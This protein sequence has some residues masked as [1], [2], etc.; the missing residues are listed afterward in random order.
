MTLDIYVKPLEN[1]FL[2]TVFGLPNCI[3]EAP[4]PEEAIEQVQQEAQKW[5]KADAVVSVAG[6]ERGR[7][8]R[9]P[10]ELIG[11]WAD[12]EQWDE[13]IEAMR[14]YRAELDANPDTI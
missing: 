1:G 12:D 14:R 2:A 5:Q 13:F 4:T 9:S 11:M 3:A 10:K 6:P 7:P 8:Q